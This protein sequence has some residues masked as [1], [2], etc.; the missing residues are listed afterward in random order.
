ML[1]LLPR[2]LLKVKFQSRKNYLLENHQMRISHWGI[3]NEKDS[4]NLWFHLPMFNSHANYQKI[5]L[6]P[7]GSY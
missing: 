2:P 1:L 6:K 4:L 5:Y 3:K 7:P